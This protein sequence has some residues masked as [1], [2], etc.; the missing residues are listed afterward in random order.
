MSTILELDGVIAGY[1]AGDILKGVDLS[2]EAGTI[3]CLIGPN[4]A[5]KSTV[6]KTVSGLLR[7]RKGTVTFD[8]HAIGRLSPKARLLLGIVHVPQERSLFPAMSVW[9]NLL[10]G[11]Y[12]IK[13]SKVLRD[14]LDEA[15]ASFPICRARAG[16]HA[17]SLSGGE[18]KQVEL[19][20]TLVL[21]PR[22]ILLDEP[23]IGLDPKSRQLVFESIRAL[24]SSGRTILLV[25]QNARSGL[26]AS[27]FAAVMESGRVQLTSTGASLLENPEVAR[28]YL[29]AGTAGH[30]TV[31]APSTDSPGPS[32]RT[33][34]EEPR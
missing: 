30:A 24:S 34:G 23:S 18:Q 14:R 17:G 28:L 20:R 12:L 31:L 8:G 13:D 25:E 5:G 10:M 11:G 3:T 4:G 9:D 26:A 15:V 7:P 2:V 22:L 21:D 32:A 27:D 19:A 6:L 16:E 1:G 29:G 33:P